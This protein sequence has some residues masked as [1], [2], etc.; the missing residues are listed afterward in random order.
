MENTQFE[1]IM[2]CL[3]PV[4][5]SSDELKSLKTELTSLKDEVA[6]IKGLIQSRSSGMESV[7]DY[8]Y[9]YHVGAGFKQSVVKQPEEE[10]IEKL[11]ARIIDN[12]DLNE[13][14]IDFFKPNQ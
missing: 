11:A 5:E 8:Q 10:K 13:L 12:T 3:E 4:Q 7:G 9:T 2:E 6:S 1:Q 14:P